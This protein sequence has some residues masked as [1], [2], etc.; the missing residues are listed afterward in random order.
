MAH[1]IEF[2]LCAE[3]LEA[4]LAAYPGGADRIELCSQLSEDG[5][6]PDD[7]LLQE[8]VLRSRLPVHVM[9]R[10]RGGNFVYSVAEFDRICAQL[11]RARALGAAGFVCGVLR[12]NGTVD[13]DR[14][15]E[16]TAIAG[17]L[18]ITFHRALDVTPD[19]FQALEDVIS[20]GCKR[21]LTSGGAV[22][23]PH[24]AATLAALVQQAGDRTQVAVG[25]GLRL[26]NAA[27]LVRTTQASHFHGTVRV[28]GTDKVD[29][30]Y[31]R[32]VITV[33]RSTALESGT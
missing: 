17:D 24:G 19:I 7:A 3:T 32:S 30:E 26:E 27:M 12:P 29:A 21:V 18:P 5:L 10:P 9:L 4:C 33:L 14:I 16:L 20:S 23:A 2:E 31:L 22:T 8:A 13:V 15:R 1:P 28:P 11:E 25:G 6:T